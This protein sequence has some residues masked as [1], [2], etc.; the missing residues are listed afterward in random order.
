MRDPATP[1]WR[2]YAL[3]VAL[4]YVALG[5][6]WILGSDALVSLLFSDETARARA[7]SVKGLV[8]VALSGA[9]VYAAVRW[10]ALPDAAIDATAP[11]ARTLPRLRWQLL[12]LSGILALP[13][14]AM[15]FVNV[16]RESAQDRASAEAEVRTR[17]RLAAAD[18]TR[19][20][21]DTLASAAALARR[22]DI[23]ALDP[24]RC[25]PHLSETAGLLPHVATIITVRRDGTVVCAAKSHPSLPRNVAD[26]PDFAD[27][28]GAGGAGAGRL[29]VNPLDGTWMV[30]VAELVFGAGGE[31]AGAVIVPIGVDRLA[32]PEES[33]PGAPGGFLAVVDPD[34]RLVA[35]SPPTRAPG[36]DIRGEPISAMALA[37]GN[38][39]A[40][41]R[42]ADGTSFIVGAAKVE[43]TDWVAFAAVPEAA[44]LAASRY[45]AVRAS[46]LGI[47]LLG[48]AGLAAFLAARRIER[49]MRAIAQA[50]HRVAQGD[51]AARAPVAGSRETAEVATRLNELL[52]RLPLVEAK[53]LDSE[54]RL[55]L[56]LAAAQEGVILYGTDGVITFAND[57]GARLIGQPSAAELLGKTIRSLLPTELKGGAQARMDAR[58]A[59]TPG[60]YEA[61]LTTPE[62]APRWL[63]ISATPL[64][65][66]DGGFT[67]VLAMLSDITER[68]SVEA[69]I[70]R[71]SRLYRALSRVNEAVVRTQDPDKLFADTCRI[72]VDEGRFL[73]AYVARYDAQMQSMVPVASSGS[74]YGASGREPFSI[75]P[76]ALFE[77]GLVATA[78]RD[79][80]AVV[81]NDVDA[82]ARATVARPLAAQA[83]FR[84]SSAFPLRAEGTVIGALVVYSEERG[85]FDD[86]LVSL[87]QQVADDVSF[88]LDVY[89]RARAR[90]RAEA[91]VR[92][93]AATLERRVA[94]RTRSLTDANRDLESFSYTVS[95]D[96][97]APVRAINGFAQLLDEHAGGSLDDEGR[98]L[99]SSIVRSSRHMGRL[100]DDLLAFAQLGRRA[101]EIAPVALAGIVERVLEEL[102]PMI[103][104]RDA[105]IEVVPGP[106]RV[107]GD[108][109]LFQQILQN[110]VANA[111]EYRK[112]GVPP[113][114]RIA[115]RE[116]GDRVEISVEDHGIGIA[117]EHHARIF[118]MFERLHPTSA[119]PGTGIGLA[120]VA[121]AV[122]LLRGEIRLASSPGEGSTFTIILPA[123]SASAAGSA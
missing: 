42:G 41:V 122:E 106:A 43:A 47:G 67:G 99:V 73:G 88:A 103:E 16:V 115:W 104:T 110:L 87:L 77:T 55:A 64:R 109:T 50:V 75:A 61:M 7:Q 12:V 116:V 53:L 27:L 84:A 15:L 57:V 90:D 62:G 34:G 22:P 21:R 60:R 78:V 69:R 93:L 92:E 54:Q 19:V 18:V 40:V 80:T 74:T 96:L 20:V 85:R 10:Y 59:G 44:A 37:V 2:P 14:V 66:P 120:V 97:R 72:V 5:A 46:L 48:I 3:A 31:P 123:G 39:T 35:H 105:T 121:R 119:H 13:L 26:H 98:R 33:A 107:S 52:D 68:K 95:H 17:A 63:Y 58:R 38:G 24:G 6:A 1:A 8:F 108:P 71:L 23:R 117:P 118:A 102:R 45:A 65:G 112:P 91:E 36:K 30:P 9:Y 82:D 100:I 113:R 49:P 56:V 4:G 70:E 28:M 83:G 81:V 114:V 111:L 79:G 101:I 76:G 32:Q 25:G 29:T 11:G 86:A 51:T 89:G 94:E